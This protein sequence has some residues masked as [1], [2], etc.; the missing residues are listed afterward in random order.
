VFAGGQLV[1]PDAA[2][3][4]SIVGAVPARLRLLTTFVAQLAS[5]FANKLAPA[6]L[7]GAALNV[8]FPDLHAFDQ[9]CSA[10]ASTSKSVFVEPSI[11][12]NQPA[13]RVLSQFER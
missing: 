6:G 3:T 2:P 5:S 8:R 13:G 4:L 11:S 7:G 10:G 1:D 12:S 9:D